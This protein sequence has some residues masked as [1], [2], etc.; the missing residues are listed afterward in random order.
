MRSVSLK[1]G[2]KN[3]D[4]TKQMLKVLSL[5]M[6]ARPQPSAPLIDGLVDDAVLQ[7]SPD[8][9]EAL[10]WNRFIRFRIGM[11]GAHGTHGILRYQISRYQYRG[12][13][14]YRRGHGTSRY[15]LETRFFKWKTCLQ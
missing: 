4:S 3:N 6:N 15:Y 13:T 11:G 2:T 5:V 9:Y 1:F 10:H 7:L 8:G 12:V 14:V